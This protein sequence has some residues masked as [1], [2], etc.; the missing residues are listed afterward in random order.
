MYFKNIIEILIDKL[1]VN[2]FLNFIKIYMIKFNRRF[3][4]N[5]DKLSLI[6]ISCVCNI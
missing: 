3:K 5:L 4:W 6:E 2:Y 1:I